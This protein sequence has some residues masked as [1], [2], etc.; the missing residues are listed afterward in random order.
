VK[1]SGEIELHSQ[2]GKHIS[3]RRSGE[4]VGSLLSFIGK[5]TGWKESV[6]SGVSGVAGSSGATFKRLPLSVLTEAFRN[7]ELRRELVMVGAQRLQRVLLMAVSNYLGLPSQLLKHYPPHPD[8]DG[9]VVPAAKGGATRASSSTA[10]ASAAA[11]AASQLGCDAIHLSKSNGV[12]GDECTLL[13]VQKGYALQKQESFAGGPALLFLAEGT[14]SERIGR[15]NREVEQ[16]VEVH[17]GHFINDISVLGAMPSCSIFTATTDAKVLCIPASTVQYLLE[18]NPIVLA[19]LVKASLDKLTVLIRNLDLTCSMSHF[20]AG[21]AVF[22]EETVV[23]DVAIVLSGR[24]RAAS[25][26]GNEGSTAGTALGK[27]APVEYGRGGV[28]GDLEAF[29]GAQYP[30]SVH[31]VRDSEVVEIPIAFVFGLMEEHPTAV[32]PFMRTITARVLS[33]SQKKKSGPRGPVGRAQSA[34]I[35][36][37]AATVEQPFR[38]VTLIGENLPIFAARLQEELKQQQRGGGSIL[39]VS[40]ASVSASGYDPNGGWRELAPWISEQE[41]KHALLLFEADAEDT[42]WT[43]LCI[44][45]AD[46]ILSIVQVEDGPACNAEE[47][48]LATAKTWAEKELVLLHS[49]ETKK[50]RNTATWLNLRPWVNKHHHIRVAADVL[51]ED[52]ELDT[53][54]D[55]T[56]PDMGRLA[57][58]L[59]GRS[60]GLCL[61]GGGAKGC[62]HLGVIMEIEKL[63]IPID[64]VGGTSIGSMVAAL[65]ALETAAHD[66]LFEARFQGMANRLS[67]IVPLVMDLTVPT[68]ALT[69]G[70]AFNRAIELVLGRTAI[71]DLWLP[72]FCV[73]TNLSHVNARTHLDGSLWRYVRASMTLTGFLPPMCDP[74]D[75]CW[76]V[77][78][79]YAYNLPHFEMQRTMGVHRVIAVEVGSTYAPN[80]KTFGDA[81]SGLSV[82]W[83][84]FRSKGDKYADKGDIQSRLMYLHNE[85]NTAMAKEAG[86]VVLIEPPVQGYGLLEWGSLKAIHAVGT[87]TA[88]EMLPKSE[89]MDWI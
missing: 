52:T 77:D 82:M 75:G 70:R 15:I 72:Y 28:L 67:Q 65:Y 56:H 68:I 17:A 48:R 24:L 8:G 62:A 3:T 5:L 89:A 49:A 73:T 40:S 59:L 2:A 32:L 33:V 80:L 41:D 58:R 54:E 37:S 6:T 16:E 14:L 27:A 84:N 44:S 34:Q 25:S 45:Q 51:D 50:P 10:K 26:D 1:V 61:G 57:R 76:L 88:K 9:T 20:E 66:T 13:D 29:T 43:K 46:C 78:G 53:P 60:V 7:H 38:T 74:K 42:A 22:E 69:T 12:V 35:T 79:G 21:A 83:S 4:H 23:E 64:V 36:D 30:C 55:P 47:T 19:N 11:N 71:E 86:G 31:A 85:V 87:A 63:G 39:H 18:T 81:V